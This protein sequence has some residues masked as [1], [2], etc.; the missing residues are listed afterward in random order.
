MPYAPGGDCQLAGDVQGGM[1]A[2]ESVRQW[3]LTCED[4]G[5][6]LKSEEVDA[7]L[8]QEKQIR[9][10]NQGLSKH[11]DRPCQTR[12][13]KLSDVGTLVHIV[14]TALKVSTFLKAAADDGRK[15]LCIGVSLAELLNA[16]DY[17]VIVQLI[18]HTWEEEKHGPV[19][20]RQNQR[21]PKHPPPAVP[22]AVTRN[23]WPYQRAKVIHQS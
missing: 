14:L 12:S 21:Y 1:L 11:A 3:K 5:I 19:A 16:F 4:D 9:E 2:K 18:V 6:G 17:D 15:S 13:N 20:S 10:E 23:N 8:I 7:I 22:R